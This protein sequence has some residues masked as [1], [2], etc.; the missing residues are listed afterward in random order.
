MTPATPVSGRADMTKAPRLYDTTP[1][2]PY[3]A[4]AKL[5]V[6]IW[7]LSELGAA[8][9]STPGSPSTRPPRPP[10]PGTTF[11]PGRRKRTVRPPRGC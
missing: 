11:H 10:G 4:R 9:M 2:D 6:A 8:Q 7:L 5:L 3:Q 1:L